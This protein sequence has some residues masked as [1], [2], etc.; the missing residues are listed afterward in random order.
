MNILR[1]FGLTRMTI[2]MI[3]SISWQVE[4]CGDIWV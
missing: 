3:E 4:L 2:E 1:V